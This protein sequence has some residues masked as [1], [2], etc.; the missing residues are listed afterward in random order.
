MIAEKTTLDF[1]NIEGTSFKEAELRFA[2]H[3]GVTIIDFGNS[4][5]IMPFFIEEGNSK[6][7]SMMYE[8]VG[9]MYSCFVETSGELLD[10]IEQI[11][12]ESL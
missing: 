8:D 6:Q 10:R 2:N 3:L 11:K 4:Y 1:K 9:N 7:Y 5:E 12:N